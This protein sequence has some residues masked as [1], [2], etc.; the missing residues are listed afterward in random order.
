MNKMSIEDL[1]RIDKAREELEE[2]FTNFSDE[3][4]CEFDRVENK[5]H[6]RPD[7]CAFLLLS[8]LAPSDNRDIVT[9]AEHD[10]IYLDVNLEELAINATEDNIKDLLRCGVRYDSESGCLSMFV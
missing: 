2:K 4:F 6:R 8:N 10:I 9:A 5:L 7:I 3:E 1:D